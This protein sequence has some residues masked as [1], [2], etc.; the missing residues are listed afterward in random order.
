MKNHKDLFSR[1][2]SKISFSKTFP[3]FRVDNET[4]SSTRIHFPIMHIKADSCRLSSRT[5]ETTH[6]QPIHNIPLSY[7]NPGSVLEIILP[8][9][10]IILILL[11]VKKDFTE[12]IFLMLLTKG[13]PECRPILLEV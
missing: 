11:V 10:F 4:S 12:P 8:S 5:S 2:L 7:F 3:L 6:F 9:V 1:L 13:N